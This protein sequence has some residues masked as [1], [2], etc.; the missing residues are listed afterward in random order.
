[1]LPIK[2][3]FINSRFKEEFRRRGIG[4]ALFTH[5]AQEKAVPLRVI[6]VDQNAKGSIA[7]L[8]Q[9]GLNCPFR[10]YEMTLDL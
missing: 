7:F 3:Q 10:Q 6:N 2:A 1:M 5:L 4:T 9:I 8:Q